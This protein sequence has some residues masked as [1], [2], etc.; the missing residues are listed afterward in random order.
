M[1]VKIWFGHTQK[2]DAKKLDIFFQY[3]WV[4]YLD[5]HCIWKFPNLLSKITQGVISIQ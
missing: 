2:M 5:L 4:G 3:S 1:G